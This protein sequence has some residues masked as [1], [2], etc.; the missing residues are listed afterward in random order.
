MPSNIDPGYL[1]KWIEQNPN[2]KRYFKKRNNNS[3]DEEEDSNST[4]YI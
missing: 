2:F 4:M 3:D 1:S